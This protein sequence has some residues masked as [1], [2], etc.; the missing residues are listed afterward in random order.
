VV[1]A[2]GVPFSAGAKSFSLL[3][4]VRPG[5]ETPP[6]ASYPMRDG[7]FITGVK[8]PGREADCSPPFRVEV[9]NIGTYTSS[10]PCVFMA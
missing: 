4:S 8:R 1:D 3:H 10:P 9:K 5:S 7:G 6:P 2:A